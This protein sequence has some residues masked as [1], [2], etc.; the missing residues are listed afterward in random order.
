MI[1]LLLA[2]Q[3]PSTV[4]QG[5]KL[6]AKS[7]ATGYC[8]GAEGAAARGP[9]LRDR[10][11]DRAYLLKV[12][13][14]GI[15]GSAMPAWKDRFSPAEVEAVVNYIVHLNGGKVD[16]VQPAGPSPKADSAAPGRQL[17][18]DQ[19]AACH[20]GKG[21]NLTAKSIWPP[22]GKALQLKLQGGETFPAHL[23]SESD[24]LTIVLDLTDNPPIRRSLETVEIASRGPF[25]WNHPAANPEDWAKIRAWLML[26]LR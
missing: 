17:Y 13:R 11:F 2:L 7:C 20:Q 25:A 12:T 21:L 24:G 16:P 1:W 3:L 4:E 14:D 19:C 9:R 15:P 26:P 10:Q 22:S 18:Q 6:F 23:V 5:S 8:H